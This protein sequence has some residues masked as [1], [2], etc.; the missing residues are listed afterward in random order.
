MGSLV[1]SNA[2]ALRNSSIASLLL[3]VLLHSEIVLAALTCCSN[4]ALKS[5]ALCRVASWLAKRNTPSINAPTAN[6]IPRQKLP[7]LLALSALSCKEPTTSGRLLIKRP[8]S[9]EASAFASMFHPPWTPSPSSL[10]TGPT[11]LAPAL[12]VKPSLA[13]QPTKARKVTLPT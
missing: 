2:T 13:P 6:D 1:V 4:A 11:L 5:S 12:V 10:T 3:S 8:A 9:D 7:R